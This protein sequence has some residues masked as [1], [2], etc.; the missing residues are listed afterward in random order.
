MMIQF[1]KNKKFQMNKAGDNIKLCCV[2]LCTIGCA[3]RDYSFFVLFFVCVFFLKKKISRLN[4]GYTTNIGC[5]VGFLAS[6]QGQFFR[7]PGK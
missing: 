7:G 3:S 4:G 2:R 5:P 6:G 1:V